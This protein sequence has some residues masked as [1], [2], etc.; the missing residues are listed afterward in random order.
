MMIDRGKGP[1]LVLIPG[2]QGRWE[3]MTRTVDALATR[4]RV[5]S[6]SLCGEPGCG[7]EPDGAEGFDAFVRQLDEVVGAAGPSPAVLCGVSYGGWIALRYAARHP[8]RVAALVLASTPPPRIELGP[9]LERYMRRPR[10]WMPVFLAR[11]AG[12]TLAEIRAALPSSREWVSFSAKHL[13]TVAR[14][15]QSPG[16]STTRIRLAAEVDFARDARA[17]MCPTLILTGEP[18][19]DGVVPPDSTRQYL[20]LI[21]NARAATLEGTGHIGLIT[22]A[23][24]FADLVGDFALRHCT[25]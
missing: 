21:P 4:V 17:V 3:W 6:Y 2:V 8:D 11:A 1:T 13:V 9:R 20:S 10:L 23:D 19:L 5:V 14:A 15:P 25:S 18:A 12:R 16:R 24:R 22:K 7:P